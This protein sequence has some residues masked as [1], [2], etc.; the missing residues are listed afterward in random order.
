MSEYGQTVITW[1]IPTMST[2]PGAVRAAYF[3]NHST[4]QREWLAV[5]VASSENNCGA[6]GSGG[7]KGP[8]ISGSGAHI[9]SQNDNNKQQIDVEIFNKWLK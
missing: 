6:L 8:H 4:K 3:G 5:N 7:P 1:S 9:I 2:H